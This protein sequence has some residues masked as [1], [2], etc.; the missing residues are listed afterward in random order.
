ME[1]SQL[2]VEINPSSEEIRKAKAGLLFAFTAVKKKIMQG[3]C[4]QSL[5]L[6]V[7][8]CVCRLSVS[9]A[10]RL[11]AHCRLSTGKCVCVSVRTRGEREGSGR[12]R[13]R[14]RKKVSDELV[15][16]Q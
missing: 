12:E 13:R 11:A 9:P 5:F 4:D 8:S 14:R 1:A 6:K 7:F 3:S 2:S 16:G 15:E 10:Q